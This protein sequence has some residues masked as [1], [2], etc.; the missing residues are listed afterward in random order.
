ML[1]DLDFLSVF[2]ETI[3]EREKQWL[4]NRYMCV[5]SHSVMSSSL[6]NSGLLT[7]RLLWPWDFP[8]K[9]T[10]VGCHFPLQGIFPTQGSNPH[11]CI[12]CIGRWILS[13]CA[14][15]DDLVNK[16]VFL[17]QIY[18]IY[19]FF[20]ISSYIFEQQIWR[21]YAERQ[22]VAEENKRGVAEE[23]Q[24]FSK[25]LKVCLRSDLNSVTV[26][27]FSTTIYNPQSR[28]PIFLRNPPTSLVGM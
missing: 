11:L 16:H 13:H 17:Y 9:N 12:S 1:Y 4:N 18:K 24:R 26:V 28:I 25:D 27:S 23:N 8:G 21:D 14:T 19:K 2:Q 5:L 15:W 10:E 3:I 22:I 6:Q 20:L 7:D